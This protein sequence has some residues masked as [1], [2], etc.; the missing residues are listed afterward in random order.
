LDESLE[1]EINL[2]HANVCKALSDPKR[3]LIH[4]VSE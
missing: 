4:Y 2:L 1:L 3:I